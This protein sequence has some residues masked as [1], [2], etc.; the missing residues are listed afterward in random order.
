MRFGL[1][2]SGSAKEKRVGFAAE[3]SA[4]SSV[5]GGLLRGSGRGREDF[6]EPSDDFNLLLLELVA[7]SPVFELDF[8]LDVG[9]G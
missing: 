2:L 1:C 8:V 7:V 9:D 6:F 3:V 4:C 5:A